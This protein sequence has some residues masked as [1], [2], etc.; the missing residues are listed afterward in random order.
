VQWGTVPSDW[1]DDVRPHKMPGCPVVALSTPGYD[2][3]TTS[4]GMESRKVE[5]SRNG[6]VQFVENLR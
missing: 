1:T 2:Q 4:S 5:N 3:I 6:D